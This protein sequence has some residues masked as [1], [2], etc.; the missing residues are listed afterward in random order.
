MLV[1]YVEKT[2]TMKLIRS[3]LGDSIELTGSA[4][5]EL[6]IIVVCQNRNF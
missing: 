1:L 5:A 2:G 4:R 3:R 6:C